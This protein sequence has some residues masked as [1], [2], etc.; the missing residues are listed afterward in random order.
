MAAPSVDDGGDLDIVE[1]ALAI[2]EEESRAWRETR[3]RLPSEG[4][5]GLVP[6]VR[7]DALPDVAKTLLSR[8]G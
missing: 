1:R 2:L 6:E 4:E 7:P 8:G 5:R 3:R